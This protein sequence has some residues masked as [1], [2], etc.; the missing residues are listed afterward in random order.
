MQFA[1]SEQ[2]VDVQGHR[3]S[4]ERRGVTQWVQISLTVVRGWAKVVACG[5]HLGYRERAWVWVNGSEVGGQDPA[6][7][8]YALMFIIIEIAPVAQLDRAT[9]F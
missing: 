7:G 5:N 6:R 1:Q 9:D 4:R 8:R 3:L 2:C